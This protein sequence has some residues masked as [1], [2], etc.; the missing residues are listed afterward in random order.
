[1][2]RPKRPVTQVATVNRVAISSDIGLLD[3]G[4]RGLAHS[5]Q[6]AYDQ[7]D[8]ATRWRAHY[9][10]RV[11]RKDCAFR[12][13]FWENTRQNTV[14]ISIKFEGTPKRPFELKCFEI[15]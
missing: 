10:V 3:L 8:N 1:M 14:R 4:R 6:G 9:C 11:F 2:K 12:E 15:S 7:Q 13:V 5:T